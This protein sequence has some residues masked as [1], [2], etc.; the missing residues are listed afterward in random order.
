MSNLKKNAILVNRITR[1]VFIYCIVYL[2]IS[3]VLFDTAVT[4][5]MNK[6]TFF[7]IGPLLT[8]L[9]FFNFRYKKQAIEGASFNRKASVFLLIVWVLAGLFIG[10]MVLLFNSLANGPLG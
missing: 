9:T 10:F 7:T 5:V 6:V 2:L 8:M 3:I 4:A 1:V